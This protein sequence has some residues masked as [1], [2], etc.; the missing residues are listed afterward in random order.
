MLIGVPLTMFGIHQQM[1]GRV[2][3][4]LPPYS[5]HYIEASGKSNGIT[6]DQT[7]SFKVTVGND[8]SNFI[9]RFTGSLKRGDQL[10]T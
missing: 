6:A 9:G 8:V 3:P 2:N 5:V 4:L 7:R 10:A 1:H